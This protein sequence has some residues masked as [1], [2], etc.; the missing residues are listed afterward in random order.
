MSDLVLNCFHFSAVLKFTK[1]MSYRGQYQARVELFNAMAITTCM[2]F[3]NFENGC[4]GFS[5]NMQFRKTDFVCDSC[6]NNGSDTPPYITLGI[7]ENVI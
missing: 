7:N 4:D 6:S 3:A 1:G 2:T 5:K